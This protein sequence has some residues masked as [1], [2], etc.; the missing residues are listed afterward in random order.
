MDEKLG[1]GRSEAFRT[2]EPR[3]PAIFPLGILEVL[4]S[5]LRPAEDLHHLRNFKVFPGFTKDFS[6]HVPPQRS[7]RAL[8]NM[9]SWLKSVN[10][11]P[12]GRAWGGSSARSCDPNART[13][14]LLPAE[15]GHKSSP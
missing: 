9:L 8:G 13:V 1:C 7:R 3:I 11:N 6:F 10:V 2:V 5:R 12:K 15:E 14:E 4:P